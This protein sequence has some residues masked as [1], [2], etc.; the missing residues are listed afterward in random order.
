MLKRPKESNWLLV[1]SV[2]A[3]L[4]FW[5]LALTGSF[6]API[7]QKNYPVNGGGAQNASKYIQPISADDRIADYTALLAWFTGVLALVS[8]MQGFF[9]YRS[10]KTARIAANAARDSADIAAD[11]AKKQL[12]AY[13]NVAGAQVYNLNKANGRYIVVETQNFGQT[14]ALDE[15]FWCGEHVREWPLQSTLSDAP[16]DLRMGVQTL[17]PGRKSVMRIPV[18]E[19][20]EFEECE[21]REGRAGVYFWGTIKYRD[22]FG[23]THFTNIRL[24]CEGEGLTSGLMHATEEGNNSD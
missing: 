19:L 8:F 20:S 7:H 14:P 2:G 5:V 3:F 12:R 13:V 9:L 16:R 23:D 1:P 15:Q 21:L 11:T 24:V 18:G 4:L 10:D 22:I 17:P 6:S